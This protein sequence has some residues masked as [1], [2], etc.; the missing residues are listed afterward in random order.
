MS[1]ILELELLPLELMPSHTHQDP[2]P[3][4]P[5][6]ASGLSHLRQRLLSLEK[7]LDLKSQELLM[8]QLN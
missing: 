1:P 4:E 5:D 2:L 7:S 8:E 3:A 6:L